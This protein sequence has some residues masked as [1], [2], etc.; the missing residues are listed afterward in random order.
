[1]L[2]IAFI[3]ATSAHTGCAQS[4]SI[5]PQLGDQ[6]A[7]P[8]TLAI[9]VATNR[10]YVVN[11]NAKVLYD[12]TQ[13]SFQAYDITDPLNPVLLKSMPTD[14]FSGEAYIDTAKVQAF[15]PNRFSTDD[16]ATED[17][18]YSFDLNEATTDFLV[19]TEGTAGR[20]AYAIDCCYPA[21]RAWITTSLNQLQYFDL[22]DISQP[23]GFINLDTPL[24]LGGDLS[25]AEVNHIARRDNQAF[26][27]REY[28][29]VLV[30]DLD[31]ADVPGS[32]GVDYWIR[33]IPNPRGIAIRGDTL[34]VVGEGNECGG[35]WCRFLMVFDV[36][37]M[38]PTVGN[39][40]T[41]VV[42][43]EDSGILV[44][45][46][47]VGKLPQ[48]VLLSQDFAFV[49]NQ[50][51]DT[52]SVI[53]LATNGVVATID[54]GEEPFSLALYTTPAGVDQY[55]YIGNVKDN[56]ISIIDV[57]TLTVVATY[58]GPQ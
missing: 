57:P 7:T 2:A 10:L 6:L 24:D 21:D 44:T 43:K 14:S 3:A 36:S 11:S 55:V 42:D 9:D 16:S 39:T 53:N 56:T 37:T 32:V 19:F 5:W 29:G 28:G 33:D 31:D 38:V 8:S 58:E 49:T 27:S 25:H 45:T 23:A 26:L 48:E 34:Y 15:V 1:M 18:L 13:G 51:D 35:S 12:W 40:T 46:I 41:I 52:V 54:V 20:D 30:V 4:G 50:D 47:V 17:R 22:N